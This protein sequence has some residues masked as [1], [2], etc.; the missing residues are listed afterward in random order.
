MAIAPPPQATV[1]SHPARR[2]DEGEDALRNL[3]MPS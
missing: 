2:R 3:F 1:M